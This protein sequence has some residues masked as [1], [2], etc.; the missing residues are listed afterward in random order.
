MTPIEEVEILR[1][2][3][4]VAGADGKCTDNERVIL[5]R[6][7]DNV[8][9]GKASFDAILERGMTDPEFHKK[10]FQI[11]KSQPEFTMETLLSV[12]I[13][14]DQVTVNEATILKNLAENL[15]IAPEKFDEIAQRVVNQRKS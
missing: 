7:A 5:Q 12:A 8:G 9:V 1:A 14:D 11:L 13:A 15:E 4:C 2:C 3:C 6:L 10:Q